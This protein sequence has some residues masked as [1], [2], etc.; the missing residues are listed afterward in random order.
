LTFNIKHHPIFDTEKVI[1][2]Y[3]K[4]DGVPIKYVCTSAKDSSEWAGDIFYRET[5]HPEFGNRYFMLYSTSSRYF[6]GGLMITS[7]DTIENV[8]F[9]MVEGP[10]GWEY[11]QHRHDFRQVGDVAI[12]GGRAYTR[13]VGNVDKPTKIF[14]VKDGEF[15]EQTT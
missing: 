13:L 2:H 8:E 10:Q 9:T 11:S 6:G 5:P 4:K 14:Y 12:D 15:H 3:S 7:A 1:N